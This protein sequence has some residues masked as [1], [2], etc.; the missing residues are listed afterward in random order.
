MLNFSKFVLMKK[1]TL[2]NLGLPE[3][4][5]F[6][7]IFMFGWTIPLIWDNTGYFQNYQYCFYINIIGFFGNLIIKSILTEHERKQMMKLCKAYI[8]A[9]K[10]ALINYFL[11]TFCRP[12]SL[13]SSGQTRFTRQPPTRSCGVRIR[14]PVAAG[15]RRTASLPSASLPPSSSSS[16]SSFQSAPCN[17]HAVTWHAWGYIEWYNTCLLD[18]IIKIL[19]NAWILHE[20]NSRSMAD[21]PSVKAMQNRLHFLK[22]FWSF[23][24]FSFVWI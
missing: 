2:L 20:P 14:S 3:G 7:Q 8:N 16:S 22:P 10:P 17:V 15:T 4:V 12:L 23:P 11:Y 13:W 1:Q 5:H 9:D 18:N 24:T 21:C 6:Q 19:M